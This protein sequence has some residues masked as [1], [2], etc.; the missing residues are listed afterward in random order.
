MSVAVLLV[1][2]REASFW[3]PQYPDESSSASFGGGAFDY[4]QGDSEKRIVYTNIVDST[5]LWKT[6]FCDNT[7]PP[8]CILQDTIGVHTPTWTLTGETALCGGTLLCAT[9]TTTW[10]GRTYRARYL[11]AIATPVGPYKFHGLPGLLYD[12][13]SGDGLVHFSLTGLRAATADDRVSKPEIG[14][15]ID[16]PEHRAR[17]TLISRQV[18]AEYG[19]QAAGGPVDN[20][21]IEKAKWRD[22]TVPLKSPRR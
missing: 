9:A 10:A 7:K 19:E 2:G 14:L 8:W 1:R 6:N 17:Q 22:Y 3:Y 18:A 21:E 16:Y 20:Y 13:K 15:R 5:I 11:P 4:V 12:V